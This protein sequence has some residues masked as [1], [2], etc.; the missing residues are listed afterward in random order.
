M[1]YPDL[2]GGCLDTSQGAGALFPQPVADRRM[3]DD[4]LDRGYWLIGHDL[5]ANLQLP[6]G[7]TAYD[8]SATEVQ[9]FASQLS[10]W[11]ADHGAA[12]VVVRPDRHV[13][14]S[15]D[16]TVLI[17]RLSTALGQLTMAA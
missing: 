4:V 6:T 12:A 7:V 17:A 3:A 5:P 9:P 8:L 1:R 16:P 13:Y 10:S 15:G 11:L 14:G 2:R